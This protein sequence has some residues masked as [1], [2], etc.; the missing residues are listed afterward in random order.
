MT[1]KVAKQEAA[2]ATEAI[3]S[4]EILSSYF[5]P[6]DGDTKL[7]PMNSS[8]TSTSNNESTYHVGLM[9]AHHF[10]EFYETQFLNSAA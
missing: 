1:C 4:A 5:F 8:S 7:V 2:E 10:N 3:F 6:S 9:R